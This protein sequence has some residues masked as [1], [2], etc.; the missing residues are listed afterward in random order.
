MPARSPS[1]D[2]T[3]YVSGSV[4]SGTTAGGSRL[5]K[6]RG[7]K[8]KNVAAEDPLERTPSL[9]GGKAST[10]VSGQGGDKDEDFEDE[11]EEMAV[12]EAVVSTREQQAEE[13]RMRAML[14]ESFDDDQMGRYEQWRAA[15]LSDPVVKRVCHASFCLQDGMLTYLGCKR[16]SVTISTSNGQHSSPRSNQTFRRRN[17][18]SSPP[19]P[20]RIHPSG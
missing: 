7:R 5:K 13:L 4:A 1:V 15:K 12:E 10:L 11:K 16:Y 9:V 2:A 19:S 6:K 3:S 8:P 18:R 14:V 17:N 20:E